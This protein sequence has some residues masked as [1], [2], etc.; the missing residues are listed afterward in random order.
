MGKRK[1]ERGNLIFGKVTAL[2]I[3]FIFLILVFSAISVKA[4]ETGPGWFDRQGEPVSIGDAKVYYGSNL[5]NSLVQTLAVTGIDVTAAT[6]QTPEIIELARGLQYDPK[7]IYEYVRNNID[8]VPY[9]G[10]LKGAT[11][12]YLDGNGNDFDQASLMIALLKASEN[13][14]GVT[15]NPQYVYGDMT[16]PTS[17]DPNQQDMQ[18]WLGTLPWA[19]TVQEVLASGGIPADVTS[20][21]TVINRVWVKVNIDGVDYEFDPAFKPYTDITGVDFASALGYDQTTFLS[22]AGG[23]VGSDYVRSL[24]E[25][26]IKTSL[27]NYTFNLISYLRTN[28]P[29]ATTEDVIGT[30]EIIP[31]LIE[32][33]PTS[34]R[35][36]VGIIEYWDTIPEEYIHT[37]R[38]QHG[39]IDKTFAIAEIAGKRLAVTYG[40]G[41]GASSMQVASTTALSV[42]EP[43][44]EGP[45]ALDAGT[46]T[47]NSEGE[48]I[49][50]SGTWNFGKIYPNGG[51]SEGTYHVYNPNPG[52]IELG[53]VIDNNPSGAFT[54]VS[55]GPGIFTVPGYGNYYIT[56]RFS[57]TNQTAGVKSAR[58][59]IVATYYGQLLPED[60]TTLTGTVAHAPNIGGNGLN[61]QS[62]L[63]LPV[64]GICRITNNGT[65]GLVITSAMTIVGTNPGQFEI[66]SGGGTG[67]I[68]VSATRNIN[69]QY[70]ASSVGNHYAKIHVNFTYDGLTY[71]SNLLSLTGETLTVPAAKLWLED[72][73]IDEESQP[74][75]GEGPVSSMFISIDH[76]YAD[77][78]GTY[79]DQTDVEYKFTRGAN[80]IIVSDFGGSSK[81]KLLEKRQ[82]KLDAYRSEGF[83]D[84]SR[85]ILTESLYI[86]GQ[87]WMK[88][89][90]LNDH[91][92][93]QLSNTIDIQHHRFGVVAQEDSFYIDVKAQFSGV[94]SRNLDQ[95][96]LRAYI[97]TKNFLN[98]ALEHG[99]LEQ[100]Q[101]GGSAVSTVRLLQ[102]ANADPAGY[103]IFMVDSASDF[104]ANIQPQLTDSGYTSEDFA[105]FLRLLGDGKKL[106]LPSKADITLDQ[107]SGM[108]Y[109]SYYVDPTDG[110]YEIGMIIK[111][112]HYGGYWS[113]NNA[114]VDNHFISSESYP[115]LVPPLGLNQPTVNDPVNITT[116][117]FLADTTDFSLGGEEPLGLHFKRSYSSE[118]HDNESILGYGWSHN[119]NIF[120]NK[121]SFEDAGLGMRKPID[122][123]ALVAASFITVDIM[124]GDP[125]VKNWVTSSLIANWAMDQLTDNAV[126]VNRNSKVLTYI[127][128][129][130]G[131]FSSPP[132]ITTDLIIN[133]DGTYS[134]LGRYGSRIDFNHDDRISNWKDAD[135][136]SML[137]SYTGE[138]LETVEDAFGRTLTFTYYPAGGRIERV[139]DSTGRFITFGFD[140]NGDLTSYTDPEGKVWGYGYDTQHKIISETDP[141]AIDTITNT[142][143]TLG[144]V[145]TQIVPR[146]DS[147]GNLYTATYNLFYSGYRNIE[148]DPEGNQTAYYFDDR[149][150]TIGKK[151]SLGHMT[152]YVYD[153]QNHVIAGTDP[154]LNTT[155]FQYDGDNNLIKTINALN[156]ETTSNYDSYFRLIDVYDPLLNRTHYDYDAEH[157]LIATTNYPNVTEQI[158]TSA[159]YFANGLTE[160][161]TDGR[162][163][164]SSMT[165]DIFGNPLTTQISTHPP[166]TY[167][168]DPIGRMIDLTD[169][170]GALTSFIYDNRGLVMSKTDPLGR[171]TSY[172]YYDDGNL[173]TKTDRKNN[174]TTYTYTPSD[175]IDTITYQDS[176]G[177]DFNYNNLDLLES[178]TNA[179]GTTTYGYD[180]ANRLAS[181]TD[182][183]GFTVSYEYDEAGNITQI[184]YPGNKTVIYT[185]D[186][187]NRIKTVTNWLDQTATY[188]YD[189]AGKL[190]SVENFNG[191]QTVYGYDNANRLTDLQNLQSDLVTS[192]AGYHYTLDENSNRTQII[193]DVPTAPV[194]LPLT[195]DYSYNAVRNRLLSAGSTL[196]TYDDEGQLATADDT[197]N[198]TN[199]TFDY[200]HRLTGISGLYNIQFKY[201]GI[202]NRLETI[203]NGITTH[204]IY[205]QSGNLL[206]EADGANNI[207]RYY[208][209]GKGLLATITPT[210]E[211]Y[212]YHFD[213][214]GNT[215][216]LTNSSQTVVNQY[217]YTPFGIL[218]SEQE[219]LMGQPF[220]FSG[221][222]G[223][224][225]E[226]NGFY[227]MRARYY[228]PSMGRFISEDP[229]GF[230]S[231][232]LNLY[233]YVGNNPLIFIDPSGLSRQINW[234]SV[235]KGGSAAVAGGVGIAF[236]AGFSET[237]VGA[238]IGVPLVWAS[239]ASMAWGVSEFISGWMGA[240][241]PV[242]P[243]ATSIGTLVY[244]GGNLEAANR[245]DAFADMFIAAATSNI[246]T[247]GGALTYSTATLNGIIQTGIK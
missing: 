83:A 117:S 209:Y 41:I 63:G 192:V 129:P 65:L 194:Y 199:Y 169:Q 88:Q 164:V 18:H 226:P 104:T 74:V 167:A 220:K 207:L 212:C 157:H 162:D 100:L 179:L 115:E 174:T 71:S 172:T 206:A 223:I 229:S 85:E 234:G 145:A 97:R 228:D 24:N 187:L 40:D 185:Y 233:A 175:N 200:E 6:T 215:V 171:T 90:T 195:L 34:P 82:R 181:S 118:N 126:S 96:K 140:S 20:A 239:S 158:T 205:D 68:G 22:A 66:L 242:T 120:I 81:G 208:I 49:A 146:L 148:E 3:I 76:P 139:T 191:T 189:D 141:M 15:F 237:G 23:E 59:H 103:K 105:E 176:S 56:I 87:S 128:L 210:S 31:E 235:I 121:H 84:T 193:E 4:G 12:T 125:G 178:L 165:Y 95:N 92:L 11:L 219:T 143:D 230:D 64:E 108:G 196:F 51:Y 44:P 111:N 94:A 127:K 155:Y 241:I 53:V 216:A 13:A 134:L 75:S 91:L 21:D 7:L 35:F 236:G 79:A 62:Y 112:G 86:I 182:P 131:S 166:V 28:F 73:L 198:L 48:I 163:T 93:K 98:S 47:N 38:I 136:N 52:P 5:D 17:L 246:S 99:V 218:I 170:A 101:A 225:A 61:G 202:G 46:R 137:F 67:T 159:T 188:T 151:N 133:P 50:L 180:E 57:S 113:Q 211:V 102:L 122:A 240:D 227:Y 243:S 186:E 19:P 72:E 89:T 214:S 238:V 70:H 123:A 168:Y 119:Y 36:P 1:I 149:G 130:D 58:L 217:S 110:K 201:D 232:D 37:V 132:G 135:N 142:Y 213:G 42:T 247:F 80:Y 27:E 231:G 14:L 144:R 203:N 147:N 32:E 204:Y 116:G 55:G 2:S 177:V 109:V 184:I 43:L 150:L 190:Y 197:V 152:T 77:Q 30:R 245:N 156:K 124:Q 78:G 224:M 16:I 60:N 107:W 154:R 69:V 160:T 26:N 10:S 8:Y 9:F 222:V 173:H 54:F 39:S 153:G 45:M 33:Y 183:H 114:I 25:A 138:N 221:Q 161:T 244:T 106:I 29:N